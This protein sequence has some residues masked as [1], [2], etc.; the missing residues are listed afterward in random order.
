MAVEY[1]FS[2]C[3]IELC[4]LN[5]SAWAGETRTRRKPFSSR[6]FM[7][8][9][10]GWNRITSQIGTRDFTLWVSYEVRSCCWDRIAWTLIIK[11]YTFEYYTEAF[12]SSWLFLAY[13]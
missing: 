10:W 12:G 9:N 5:S 3:C 4:I 1:G 2:L 6:R 11:Y 7:I 13:W 8:A